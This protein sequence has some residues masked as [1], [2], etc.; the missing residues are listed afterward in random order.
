VSATRFAV[1]KFNDRMPVTALQILPTLLWY[2]KASAEL[3][4]RI[5]NF[6]ARKLKDPATWAGGSQTCVCN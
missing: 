4:R 2:A 5:A 3:V 6:V 1:S